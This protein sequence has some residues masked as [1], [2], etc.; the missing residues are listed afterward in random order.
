LG[1]VINKKNF[2]INSN[3]IYIIS[4]LNPFLYIYS[5]PN[6]EFVASPA[7]APPEVDFTP[8]DAET[9]ERELAEAAAAPLPGTN[10]I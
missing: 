9:Y 3:F 6:L 8:K 4:L 7:L 5:N 1:N 2:K 10:L